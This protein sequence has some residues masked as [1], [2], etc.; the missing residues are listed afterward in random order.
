MSVCIVRFNTHHSLN[1][2][3]LLFEAKIN[4]DNNDCVQRMRD[5]TGS[6]YRRGAP[7]NLCV[8]GTAGSRREKHYIN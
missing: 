4:S 8:C 3:R 6:I 7:A 2:M 1:G 5:D